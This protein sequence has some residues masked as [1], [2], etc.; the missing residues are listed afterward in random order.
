MESPGSL[1][2]D[3]GQRLISYVLAAK[4]EIKD[5]GGCMRVCWTEH[6]VLG[7]TSKRENSQWAALFVGHAVS[8]HTVKLHERDTCHLWLIPVHS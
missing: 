2:A 1:T 7:W 3:P 8:L 6:P 4:V 5:D